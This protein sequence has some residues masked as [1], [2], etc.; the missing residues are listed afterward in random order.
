MLLADKVKESIKLLQEVE[1]KEG[2]YLAFSGGK[3]SVVIKSL[4]DKAGVKYDAHYS[5]TTID[6]P[7]LIKYIKKYHKDVKWDNP[8]MSLAWAIVKHGYPTRQARWCCTQYKERGGT[9]RLVITG[10]RAEESHKRAGRK[11]IETCYKQEGKRYLNIILWWS[12]VDVWKYI[13]DN[14]L[15]YC[16]LYDEGWD[17]I[18]CLFCPMNTDRVHHERRY[19]GYAKLFRIAFDRRYEYSRQRG[20]SMAR[21]FKSGE[22]AFNFW[23]Y[24]KRKLEDPDQGVMF[25]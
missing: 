19:P 11:V 10:I 20:L 23:L 12:Q 18:G 24:E 21:R 5:N 1:P 14:E 13:Q 22:E 4:A 17:R 16:S 15:L 6:P 9:G 2:Y 7:E 25:E 3:D 8:K